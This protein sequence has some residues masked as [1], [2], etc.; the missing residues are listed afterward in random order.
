ME[1][2]NLKL[3]LQILDDIKREQTTTQQSISS[4]DKKIDLLTQRTDLELKQIREL[5]AQQN[6]LLEEHSK[7]SEQLEI[8]NR[9]TEEKLRM[10]ILGEGHP[11][12]GQ[13][14]AGRVEKL[15]TP[16]KWLNSTKRILIWAG[17]IA[18]A[19]I[20]IQELLKLVL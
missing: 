19:L 15:E 9:L 7:R 18:T 5:D 17:A 6:S 16:F 20:A 8:Q 13:T 2:E 3:C 1:N 11:N 14:L 4:V 12:P 10:E